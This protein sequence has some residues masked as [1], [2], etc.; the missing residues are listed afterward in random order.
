MFMFGRRHR[1]RYWTVF[2]IQHVPL[3]VFGVIFKLCFLVGLA[4]RTSRNER[5]VIMRCITALLTL[6]LTYKVS[7]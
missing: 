7:S 1:T 3:I 5:F 2:D 4:S 6:T